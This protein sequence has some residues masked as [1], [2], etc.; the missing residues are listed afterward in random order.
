[1][2]YD[3][4]RNHE[5]VNRKPLYGKSFPTD[6]KTVFKHN[7]NQKIIQLIAR[8]V[9]SEL[10][11]KALQM[12]VNAIIDDPQRC[13]QFLATQNDLTEWSPK[14]S[15]LKNKCKK[16][17]LSFSNYTQDIVKCT[18]KNKGEPEDPFHY[19]DEG[20]LVK[21]M[22]HFGMKIDLNDV[23]MIIQ[24]YDK[25]EKAESHT[26]ILNSNFLELIFISSK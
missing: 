13:F 3:L 26:K 23:G 14:K 1:M 10:Q 18:C 24:L 8:L 9:K 17:N 19:I 15:I 11:L 6:K 5:L 4:D 20:S 22:S 16:H 2:P 25:L 7:T 12:H 21:R